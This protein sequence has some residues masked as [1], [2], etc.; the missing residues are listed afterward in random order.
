MASGCASPS[1]CNNRPMVVQDRSVSNIASQLEQQLSPVQL[2]VLRQ[3]SRS[4]TEQGAM[5]FL[6]GGVV[7]DILLHERP[8][9]LD[10]VVEG[11]TAQFSSVLADQLGGE[12]VTRSQFGTS[13]LKIGKVHIDLA[14]ARRESYAHPGALP[15]VAPGTIYED[16]ARRDF[17]A[18]AMAVSLGEESWGDLLDPFNGRRDLGNGLI[19]VLHSRSFVDDATRI[20]RA[21]RYAHRMGFRLERETDRQ[22]RR[23]LGQLDGIS[24]DRIRHEVQ[25]DFRE[26][27][28]AEIL[29]A[30][31]CMGVLKRI[32][33][34]LRIEPAVLERLRAVRI[35]PTLENDL[36]LMALLVF[37]VPTRHLPQLTSRLNLDARWAGVVRDVG[38][39]RDSFTLLM[40]K[41]VRRSQ[42]YN[43]LRNLDV[44]SIE[45]C[46]IA[47]DD[48][49]VKQRLELFLAKLRHMK[50]LLNGNDLIALGVPE[51][52][53]VGELLDALLAARLDGFLTTRED[54]EDLVARSLGRSGL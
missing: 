4:S 27:K 38:S 16:L 25:R 47:T 48:P 19:R 2:E 45:G 20:L 54:E 46:A 52:P 30:A 23:D 1:G 35:E 44:A 6:V 12:V 14:T 49:L 51:G 41:R 8:V 11:G 3:V 29:R 17:S 13:K 33:P 5:V 37:S 28:V 10:L 18:N 36:R 22:L 39:V 43:Q 7:R 42:V 15:D 32:H 40:D 50:T 34:G 21:I 9:D 26:S 24:G 31:Q 53:M